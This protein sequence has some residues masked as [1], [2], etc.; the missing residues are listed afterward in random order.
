M[1]SSNLTVFYLRVASKDPSLFYRT[2]LAEPS[3][4]MPIVYTPTVGE[5]QDG[6]GTWLDPTWQGPK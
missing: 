1:V 4:L 2:V 6:T 3:F 5:A